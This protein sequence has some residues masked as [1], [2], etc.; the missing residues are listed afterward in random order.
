MDGLA[1]NMAVLKGDVEK[2]NEVEV[3]GAKWTRLSTGARGVMAQKELLDQPT[4]E[5][6]TVFGVLGCVMAQQLPRR[7]N[8]S[9]RL[10][11]G[12]AARR[13]AAVQCW[14]RRSLSLSHTHTYKTPGIG[15]GLG[16]HWR[17]R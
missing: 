1:I 17:Y 4:G 11:A 16:A 7:G 12:D 13:A 15:K 2:G 6:R 10:E 14:R 5:K 8:G 3:E 9:R